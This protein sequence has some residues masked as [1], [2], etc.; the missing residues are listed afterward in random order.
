M[1][2][3]VRVVYFYAYHP[4]PKA[5]EALD[6]FAPDT[7]RV[8]TSGPQNTYWLEICKRWNGTEDLVFIEQDNEITAEVLPS[9]AECDQDWCTFSYQGLFKDMTLSQ[10]LGCTKFSA[11]LQRRIPHED[12]AGPGMV[13]HLI[14]FRIGKLFGMHRLTCHVHGSV[15]HYHDYRSDPLHQRGLGLDKKSITETGSDGSLIENEA[16]HENPGTIHPRQDGERDLPG[17]CEVRTA[18]F[19]GND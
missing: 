10:S 7:E 11:E 2:G 14:D 16:L 8:D 1:A 4:H 9:F 12:I 17:S 19:P 18:R 5:L 3:N 6:R 13:W 15:K